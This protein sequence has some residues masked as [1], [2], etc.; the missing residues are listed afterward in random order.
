MGS[1]WWL[2]AFHAFLAR[3][4]PNFPNASIPRIPYFNVTH[5]TLLH[6][7][8]VL[9]ANCTLFPL[10]RISTPFVSTKFVRK[11]ETSAPEGSIMSFTWAVTSYI[12]ARVD[13]ILL[14]IVLSLNLGVLC[15]SWFSYSSRPRLLRRTH[16]VAFGDEFSW[17]PR[18]LLHT[19]LDTPSS[20]TFQFA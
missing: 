7:A 13:L 3:V 15:R 2:T 5:A 17:L 1:H 20:S 19:N 4:T 10:N 8:S 12:P 18:Y 16:H 11:T 14:P 6:F 9:W